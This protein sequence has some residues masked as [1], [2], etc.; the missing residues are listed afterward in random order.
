MKRRRKA[1]LSIKILEPEICIR[2][3][4]DAESKASNV[5]VWK[6]RLI[7]GELTECIKEG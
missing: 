7:K 6:K 3:K 2:N 4:R 5:V 1:Y